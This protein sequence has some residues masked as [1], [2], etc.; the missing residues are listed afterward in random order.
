MSSIKKSFSTKNV[1]K[2]KVLFVSTLLLTITSVILAASLVAIKNNNIIDANQVSKIETFIP[3]TTI[4][5]ILIV[6]EDNYVG[7]SEKV[8]LEI[9]LTDSNESSFSVK[10]VD[11]LVTSSYKKGSSFVSTLTPE[12][13]SSEEI[14]EFNA[15][16]WALTQPYSSEEIPELLENYIIQAK[17]VNMLLES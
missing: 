15:Y 10:L 7:S 16:L 6:A 3:D 12:E 4:E 9:Y 2:S 5:K 8:Q 1:S 11:N 17:K 13:Q 14:K